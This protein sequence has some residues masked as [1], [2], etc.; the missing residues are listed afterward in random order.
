[1]G[2]AFVGKLVQSLLLIPWFLVD[3]LVVSMFGRQVTLQPYGTL[4][5]LGL[6]VGLIIALLFARKYDRPPTMVLELSIFLVLI[7]FPI[8]FLFNA[9]AYHPGAFRKLI[10]DPSRITDLG[11]GF[12]S[13]GG[14]LG[15]TVGGLVWRAVRKRSL[16]YV[17]ECAAFAG[18]FGWAISRLG[19][20]VTH[21]H[22]GRVSHFFLA[23]DDF[24]VGAPPYFPRHDLGFY[25]MLVMTGIA[26]VFAVLARN[27]KPV[28]FYVGLLPMLYAPV[29]FALDFLRAPLS[30]GGDVRYL[31]L[32][33]G[34][35]G[36]VVLFMA[37]VVVMRRVVSGGQPAKEP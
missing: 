12:S 17:G 6:V 34:Q 22:P 9:F 28:G 30:E 33:P 37:G 29:R 16:L 21:D 32:T 11:L 31:G 13:L 15:A 2:V 23:V 8:S 4:V 24:H 36:A 3:P 25:D 10:D 18:P 7:A 26:V 35:Y 27:P 19:C 5:W 1:M 14:A 20:F